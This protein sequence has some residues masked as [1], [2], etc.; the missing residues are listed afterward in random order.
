[1][2]FVVLSRD[3][4]DSCDIFSCFFLFARFLCFYLQS[5]G[6]QGEELAAVVIV[7]ST[8]NHHNS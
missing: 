5:A 4:A 1:M 8:Q 2:V 7:T 3:G 6:V